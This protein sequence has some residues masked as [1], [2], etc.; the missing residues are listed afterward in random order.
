MVLETCTSTND[1]VERSALKGAPHGFTVISDLQTAGRGRLGNSWTSPSGGIWITILFRD[2]ALPALL[3]SLTLVGAIAVVKTINTNFKIAARVRW[4]ND[5]IFDGRKLSGTLVEGRTK[6]NELEYALLGIGVNANFHTNQ[7]RNVLPGATTL[8]DILRHEIDR[9]QLICILL[10]EV[11]S[12]CSLIT[13]NETETVIDFLQQN[14]CSKG[15][16]I[17]IRLQDH[18]I[19][20]VF[21]DY[22][23]LTKVQLTTDGGQV[24]TLDTA[25]VDS[26]EYI[27]L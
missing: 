3:N 25:A 15:K 27:S 19:V 14:E 7:L 1:V 23:D 16:R 8:L 18:E 9:E 11:E 5:I 12:L 17:K 6:G 13:K 24:T 2:S 26:A 4:P 10:S 21:R 22:V 20:G